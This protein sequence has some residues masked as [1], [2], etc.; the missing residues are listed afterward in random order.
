MQNIGMPSFASV[1][2]VGMHGVGKST[3]ALIA[4]RSLNYR[5]VDIDNHVQA[6]LGMQAANYIKEHSL[7]VYR[8]REHEILSELFERCDTKCVIACGAAV[9]EYIPNKALVMKF[10][11]THPVIHVLADE[12]RI[13]DYLSIKDIEFVNRMCSTKYQLYRECSNYEFFNLTAQTSS[14]SDVVTAI[15]I[16]QLT[17]P[18]KKAP[19]SFL[20]LKNCERDCVRF[21]RAVLGLYSNELDTQVAEPELRSYTYSISLRFPHTTVTADGTQIE[22]LVVGADC[23]EIIIDT[24][25]FL[26]RQVRLEAIAKYI[27]TVRRST[28]LPLIYTVSTAGLDFSQYRN[29]ELYFSLLE[30]GLRNA[31]CY[32]NVDLKSIC[33]KDRTIDSFS[34]TV[35][36]PRMRRLLF[37]DKTRLP[38]PPADRPQFSWCS[39]WIMASW[40]EE[41][42]P[43]MQQHWWSSQEPKEILNFAL[44]SPCRVIRISKEAVSYQD[45]YDV[46]AFYQQMSSIASANGSFLSVFNTG[47]IGRLSK[48]MNQILTPVVAHYTVDFLLDQTLVASNSE[49]SAYDAQKALYSS[50]ALPKLQFYVVGGPMISKSLSPTVHNSAFRATGLPHFQSLYESSN[51]DDIAELIRH[52]DFGGLAVTVPHKLKAVSMADSLSVHARV[53]GAVDTL[54]PER[55]PD[56]MRVSAIRGEN[57]DWLGIRASILA[58]LSP[59]NAVTRRTTALCIGAGGVAR[60]AIYAFIQLGVENILLYNRTLEHAEE[61]ARHF[62]SQ[63]PLSIPATGPTHFDSPTITREFTIHVLRSWDLADPSLDSGLDPPTIIVSG[64]PVYNELP[65]HMFRRPTGGVAIDLHYEN[66][67][68]K[69]LRQAR[70][71]QDRGWIAV[72]G[73]KVLPEIVRLQFELWTKKPAPINVMNKS[74]LR[75]YEEHT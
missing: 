39:S 17:W 28:D 10:R 43:A 44:E 34:E 64:I 5:F 30:Y 41:V 11:D 27:S 57:T 25:F 35:H 18:S 74:L 12:D 38:I 7:L 1:V 63:S 36:A 33:Q 15:P 50:F 26:N 61:L 37:G 8:Q 45:N 2:L 71:F 24:G 9:I 16:D 3:L 22:E 29:S 53:I 62:N 48:I 60:A 58:H 65:V 32:V 46:I 21:L 42:S 73:L 67:S 59:V 31:A 52:D 4:A 75:Y 72:D 70:E 56:S 13:A 47:P 14:R 40:H 51:T 55:Q 66:L 23:V 19:R 68:S 69:V 6:V 20:I 54:I 49:L